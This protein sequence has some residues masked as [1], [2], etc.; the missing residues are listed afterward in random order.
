MQKKKKEKKGLTDFFQLNLIYAFLTMP[1][2]FAEQYSPIKTLIY[3]F[4]TPQINAAFSPTKMTI[5]MTIIT[6]PPIMKAA[7]LAI[8]FANEAKAV[9]F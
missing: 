7:L 4:L 3:A 8:K 2:V 6:S 9:G 5:I 1:F